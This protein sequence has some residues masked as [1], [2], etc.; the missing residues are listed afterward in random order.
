[1]TLPTFLGIGVAR[2]GTTWLHSLLASHP[3]I[4][5]PTQRKE[6]RFFDEYYDYGIDW[7]K[8]FF[9]PSELAANYRAIGE[10]SPQYYRCEECPGRILTS[11]PN[12]KLIVS[13]R[14]PVDRA[15]SHYGFYVQRR[16]FA[17][18]FDD[19]LTDQPQVLEQ[20]Y[21]HK[22]LKRYLEFFERERILVM[23]FEWTVTDVLDTKKSL[24][25]FL[26][27]DMDKFPP[28]A[29]GGKVNA[30]KVPK[31]RLFYSVAAKMARQLRRWRLDGLVDSVKHLGIERGLHLGKP[32]PPL[33][34]EK[35]EKLS[36]L[37]QD[38]IN[39]LE[40]TLNIDLSCWKRNGYSG[41]QNAY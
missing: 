40:T 41:K 12:A 10:F 14:H 32:L 7:Y 34:E 39:L 31:A 13:L 24:A 17:G 22:Y 1:M 38:D 21:Y 2:G 20:G 25:E 18:S 19:F 8:S 5:M 33:H 27:V 11:L 9:P 15:Y 23:V 26:N 3:D 28:S 4:Y 36:Q 30:S 29:G 16:N 37:Y 35:K 6:I